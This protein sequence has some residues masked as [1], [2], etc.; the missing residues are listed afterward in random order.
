MSV[1]LTRSYLIKFEP[2]PKKKL[3]PVYDHNYKINIWYLGDSTPGICLAT[4]L[5]QNGGDAFR[6][7]QCFTHDEIQ[8]NKR[9]KMSILDP[10]TESYV[11]VY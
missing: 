9:V 3:I 5:I 2:I 11:P 7:D 4:L 8:K 10:L 6:R 1:V